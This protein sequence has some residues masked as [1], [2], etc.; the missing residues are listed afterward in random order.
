MAKHP[1]KTR[2]REFRERARLTQSELAKLMEVDTT[3]ISRHESGS[4]GLSHTEIAKY[5][6]VFKCMSH[7]LFFTPEQVQVEE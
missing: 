3:T 1:V 2:I 4:R 7:E 6:Q 5:C